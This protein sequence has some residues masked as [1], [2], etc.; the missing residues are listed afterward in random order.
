MVRTGTIMQ[1]R[2]EMPEPLK[3]NKIWNTEVKGCALR[4]NNKLVL[5]WRNKQGHDTLYFSFK[6]QK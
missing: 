3:K 2:K 6:K 5:A 4:K 1:S